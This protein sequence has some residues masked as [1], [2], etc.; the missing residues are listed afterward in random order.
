MRQ[1]Q[2]FF[3]VEVP[4]HA[5]G[6]PDAVEGAWRVFPMVVG[7]V[8]MLAGLVLLGLARSENNEEQPRFSG[9]PRIGLFSGGGVLMVLG[10]LF[11]VTRMI[12]WTSA[13]GSL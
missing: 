6:Q 10:L 3:P 13:L 12:Q 1:R 4:G 11:C 7:F 2:D 9:A 5:L 8:L